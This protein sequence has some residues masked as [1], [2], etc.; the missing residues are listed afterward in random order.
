MKLMCLNCGFTWERGDPHA[1]C[2]QCGSSARILSAS[3]ALGRGTVRSGA[4]SAGRVPAKEDNVAATDSPSTPPLSD[5]VFAQLRF[6]PAQVM[7][8]PLAD[9]EPPATVTLIGK[10]AS[11]P[12]QISNP[13]LLSAPGGVSLTEE[14][15]D[16]LARVAQDMGSIVNL[17]DK[18]AKPTKG[19][20]GARAV[21]SV[22]FYGGELSGEAARQADMIEVSMSRSGEQPFARTAPSVR[23]MG[24]GG[25]LEPEALWRFLDGLRRA[26]GGAPVGFRLAG[27]N[28][29]KDV[30][31]V[32]LAEPD[33]LVLEACSDTFG[34]LQSHLRQ[35]IGIPLAFFISRA[36]NFLEEIGRRSEVCLVAHGAVW[37]GA[38]V[39]KVLAL[40]ADAVYLSTALLVAMGCRRCGLCNVGPCPEGLAAGRAP[41]SQRL[42]VQRAA[43][44]LHGFLDALIADVSALTRIVGKNNVHALNCEDLVGLDESV[45]RVLGIAFAGLP[46]GE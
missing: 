45:A 2:P 1:S 35:E 22:S 42:D 33:F 12:L 11:R 44:R 5:A 13:L 10:R 25:A 17:R 37:S 9:S 39:V 32:L 14:A 36:N 16:V 46:R 30:K 7:R 40:G 19:R 6:L 18:A 38:D 34:E 20:R 43:E 24:E 41:S 27:G 21:L 29:E 28:V 3:S 26:S 31:N 23:S 15:G 8:T 4:Q